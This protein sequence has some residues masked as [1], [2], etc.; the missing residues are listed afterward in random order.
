MPDRIVD[1]RIIDRPYKAEGNPYELG[2]RSRYLVISERVY[3]L[4][5]LLGST[6][7]RLLIAAPS[8]ISI[9]SGDQLRR[10]AEK[11]EE[12]ALQRARLSPNEVSLLGLD[13]PHGQVYR[14]FYVGGDLVKVIYSDPYCV[15]VNVSSPERLSIERILDKGAL[16]SIVREKVGINK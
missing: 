10:D 5:A 9:L 7:N 16:E 2:G 4:H 14:S 8:D 13:L 6:K 15:E 12:H 11:A 1:P 3:G